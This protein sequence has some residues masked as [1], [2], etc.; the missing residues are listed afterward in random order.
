MA[1]W[2]VDD[3]GLRRQRVAQTSSHLFHPNDAT[4]ATRSVVDERRGVR[5]VRFELRRHAVHRL[6]RRHFDRRATRSRRC[7][8]TIAMTTPRA[9]ASGKSGIGTDLGPQRRD[10]VLTGNGGWDLTGAA[11]GK[12]TA[13]RSFGGGRAGASCSPTAS[14]KP[15]DF[16][17]PYD[18]AA[19]EQNDLDFGSGGPVGAARTRTSAT[20]PSHPHS[21]G[22]GGEAGLRLPARPRQPRR[23]PAGPRRG[24]RRRLA[25]RARTAGYGAGP[26]YG[27]ATAATCT[28]SPQT[29]SGAPA[30]R[31]VGRTCAR[32]STGVD[33]SREPDAEPR[34]VDSEHRHVRLRF[35]ARP[36]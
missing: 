5:R 23:L 9:P 1:G 26:R 35:R 28:W 21:R 33:G 3:P 16:F 27:P 31:F 2:P 4:S 18:C 36:W 30:A 15:V 25:H 11:P 6:D 22:D 13:E 32:T 24:R 10:R 8:T 20:V 34:G 17:A 29:A 12:S 7:S 19:L 14:L